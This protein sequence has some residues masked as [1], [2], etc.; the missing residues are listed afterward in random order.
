MTGRDQI[1]AAL[2]GVVT[3]GCILTDSGDMQRYLTDWR[4]QFHGKA[5]CVVRPSST[6]EV[7]DILRCCA[8]MNV[9]V[10]P[11]GGNTG[12]AGG[13]IPDDSAG[14][15]VISLE[16]MNRIRALDATALLI[17]AEAGVI[18]QTAQE[19]AR[20]AGRK[21]PVSIASEGSATI[22]GIVATNAGGLNVLR[23]GMTRDLVLGLEVVL[24]DGTI[25]NGMRKLRK[26]N[27]GQDWK[28]LF[29]GTEGSLGLVTAAVLR[30]V[31][32]P[33]H[34]AVAMVSVE[35]V[36]QAVSLLDMA[37]TSVGETLTA[38]ELLSA[39]ALAH[40]K[41]HFG[42][43]APIRQGNWFLLI[44]AASSLSGLD[45]AFED[46]MTTAFEQALATDGV[47]AASEAQAN[48]LWALREHITE[49]ESR[50]GYSMKHDVSL[51]LRSIASFIEEFGMALDAIDP[52]AAPNVFGHLGDGNLHVNVILSDT[53]KAQ[54]IMQTVHDLV[55]TRG[56]SISAEHGLGQYRLDEW[57]RLTPRAERELVGLLK[58]TL[59]PRAILN[60]G[61]AV[62]GNE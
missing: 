61:K 10:V 6:G 36:D 11:H 59:D 49:A 16:R 4:R 12:L 48:A 34:R 18:L 19:A 26:N 8:E 3:P 31:P 47:V 41:R 38:F 40:V 54:V 14:Q 17:E 51:P 28:Q 2:S 46:L 57:M 23:Y 43:E 58:R 35:S 9:A 21:L 50:A 56:G 15:V 20:A 7:A 45:R 1:I 39:S 62:P 29:I 13:A 22:G 42:K 32:K 52:H 30:L 60:P 55:A 25:V 44:E 24:A 33:R 53:A 5:A 37:L 27:A